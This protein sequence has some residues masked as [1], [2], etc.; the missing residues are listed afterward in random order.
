MNGR[1]PFLSAA[2]TLLAETGCTVRKW[3]RRSSGVAYTTSED[4]GIE[5]PEPRGPVSFS[6]FAHEV[7]HQVLHRD[8]S[9]PRWLEEVEAWE[10]ALGQFDRFSLPGLDDARRDAAKALRYA[11]RKTAKRC[12]PTT[13]RAVL[14]RYPEWVWVYDDARAAVVEDIRETLLTTAGRVS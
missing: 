4:W 9:E 11:A 1:E 12:S 3:R 8:N 13:A 14:A 5:V 2:R 10:F 6:T 7:G